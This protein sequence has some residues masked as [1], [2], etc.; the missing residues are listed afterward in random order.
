MLQIPDVQPVNTLSYSDTSPKLVS[1]L[2]KPPPLSA[3]LY[4]A[5]ATPIKMQ[6]EGW[7]CLLCDTT[8]TLRKRDGGKHCNQCG[9]K[10]YRKRLEQNPSR[11]RYVILCLYRVRI[12]TTKRHVVLHS[13]QDWKCGICGTRTTPHK[14]Y[15][16]TLCNAC[17]KRMRTAELKNEDA[18]D[19][20]LGLSARDRRPTL[21]SLTLLLPHFVRWKLL[22]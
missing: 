3:V 20:L 16:G 4:P 15:K 19:S 18:A 9:Q 22:H 10:Q 6:S 21:S 8:E 14:R 1:D 2:E 11:V 5:E 7:K 12:R 17:G 13:A